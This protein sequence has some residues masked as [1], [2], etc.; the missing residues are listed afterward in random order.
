MSL[1]KTKYIVND[2]LV[3]VLQAVYMH[4]FD[5]ETRE[6]IL[7][8]EFVPDDSVRP[9]EV[10]AQGEEE[11]RGKMLDYLTGHDDEKAI[12]I[13]SGNYLLSI[14]NNPLLKT[15]KPQELAEVQELLISS[16]EDFF[17]DFAAGK[18]YSGRNIY[19][20]LHD[21][22]KDQDLKLGLFRKYGD[23]LIQEITNSLK[24][25]RGSD[26]NF[27]MKKSH[28]KDGKE[29]NEVELVEKEKEKKEERQI[30]DEEAKKIKEALKQ[31]YISEYG[32]SEELASKLAD[33]NFSKYHLDI[34]SVEGRAVMVLY[35]DSDYFELSDEQ[36]LKINIDSDSSPKIK[37]KTAYL[38]LGLSEKEA[39]KKAEIFANNDGNT[40][41]R[42]ENGKMHP[43]SEVPSKN[44][45]RENHK[46]WISDFDAED[47][48]SESHQAGDAEI[49]ETK[50]QETEEVQP[51]I[52]TQQQ[53]TDDQTQ[54]EEQEQAQPVIADQPQE[55]T[56]QQDQELVQD[57]LLQDGVVQDQNK[58]SMLP[59]PHMPYLDTKKPVLP[60]FDAK[61]D[62]S[63]QNP[64]NGV[65]IF[66][67]D[68][69]PNI[70]N[71]AFL[72]QTQLSEMMA[73]GIM[74]EEMLEQIDMDNQANQMISSKNPPKQIIRTVRNISRNP[75]RLTEQQ[76]M[77]SRTGTNYRGGHTANR[78][79]QNNSGSLSTDYNEGVE[80]NR[81]GSGEAKTSR[82]EQ[83]TKKKAK[84]S[85]AK[86]A[87]YWL[88]AS[89]A[90]GGGL[91]TVGTA[92]GII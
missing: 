49:S 36:T 92:T 56:D 60:S 25:S 15:L 72:P 13:F 3:P 79:K 47:F 21:L 1:I 23:P 42:D 68:Q 6:K 58:A 51:H 11:R 82:N 48:E 38:K 53:A 84:S 10:M 63:A 45:M 66:L 67:Q 32:F 71:R 59:D 73:D 26:L 9:L 19:S 61:Q 39:Q 4:A 18:S 88:L 76:L 50:D 33:E 70:P 2:L 81:S 16:V 69:K 35:G 31:M 44:F 62:I 17:N 37:A 22:D 34:T 20:T 12:E 86:K 80:E 78:V 7:N 29:V 28:D 41:Q 54:I 14:N 74:T 24:K 75:R 40:R 57:Q 30:S 52:Q 65:N 46:D 83:T 89:A 85:L 91:V 43:D 27:V 55:D 77:T 87:A 8:N 64:L 90:G 5:D